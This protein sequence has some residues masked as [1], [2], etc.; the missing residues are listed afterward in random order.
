MN[1]ANEKDDEED[2][3]V[4]PL[5]VSEVRNRALVFTR[6]LIASRRNL[7]GKEVASFL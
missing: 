3:I 1:L 5:P 6:G 2:E 4:E 7:L